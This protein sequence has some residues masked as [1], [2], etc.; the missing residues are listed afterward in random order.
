MR[1]ERLYWL[2]PC[3]FLWY[4]SYNLFCTD[5]L[6]S[7][8]FEQ[9]CVK[10]ASIHIYTGIYISIYIYIVLYIIVYVNA[11]QYLWF[12]SC[13]SFRFTE[14][15]SFYF[16]F[17]SCY[18]YFIHTKLFT[19]FGGTVEIF[20]WFREKKKIVKFLLWFQQPVDTKRKFHHK[21]AR[22]CKYTIFIV[23]FMGGKWNFKIMQLK[24]IRC[25]VLFSFLF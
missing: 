17:R 18:V 19:F 8:M 4:K 23:Y 14:I 25:F 7:F 21:N 5:F 16:L 6:F 15:I 24:F 22:Y 9:P 12:W 1:Y 3:P 20:R 10:L 2:Q 13:I 11:C